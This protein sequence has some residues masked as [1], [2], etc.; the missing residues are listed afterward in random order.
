MNRLVYACENGNWLPMLLNPDN[1]LG[2]VFRFKYTQLFRLGNIDYFEEHYVDPAT[3]T[4]Y[5]RVLAINTFCPPVLRHDGSV[6]YLELAEIAPYPPHVL[7]NVSI[8][9]TG[10]NVIQFPILLDNWVQFSSF[11]FQPPP[12]P[13]PPPAQPNM[14]LLPA[15]QWQAAHQHLEFIRQEQDRTAYETRQTRDLLEQAQK[16]IAALRQSLQEQRA[17]TPVVLTE[18]LSAPMPRVETPMVLAET[19]SEPMPVDES[20]YE[21]V[22]VVEAKD[23]EPLIDA[24]HGE[25]LESHSR[26]VD[27]VEHPESTMTEVPK[28]AVKT[29][30]ELKAERIEHLK[31]YVQELLLLTA[32][33]TYSLEPV[34]T[35]LN[36]IT[37]MIINK[38]HLDIFIAEIRPMTVSV[39]ADLLSKKSV[40]VKIK[41]GLLHKLLEYPA[42]DILETSKKINYLSIATNASKD[43]TLIAAVKKLQLSL[44]TITE[45]T[46]PEPKAEP[47]V[48]NAELR[49]QLLAA[50]E[51]LDAKQIVELITEKPDLI[52]DARKHFVQRLRN[53]L[54]QQFADLKH[55]VVLLNLPFDQVLSTIHNSSLPPQARLAV[56]SCLASLTPEQYYVKDLELNFAKLYMELT[57]KLQFGDEEISIILESQKTAAEKW[58]T[59]KV[60]EIFILFNSS[61]TTKKIDPKLVALF[62]DKVDPQG[63]SMLMH[64]I[65]NGYGAEKLLAILERA[66][67]SI[68]KVDAQNHTIWHYF[69]KYYRSDWRTIVSI[70]RDKYEDAVKRLGLNLFLEVNRRDAANGNTYLHLF[71]QHKQEEHVFAAIQLLHDNS[72]KPKEYK[73]PFQATVLVQNNASES[74]SLLLDKKNKAWGNTQCLL[75]ANIFAV[76]GYLHDLPTDQFDTYF[77]ERKHFFY[78]DEAADPILKMIE[79]KDIIRMF[80]VLEAR[81]CLHL[82]ASVIGLA[83]L[84][85][86][87]ESS[88][89]HK[90]RII[91]Y[92]EMPFIESI[93]YKGKTVFGHIT[94]YIC[95]KSDIKLQ[96]MY[97]T[98]KLLEINGEFLHVSDTL[99]W[100]QASRFLNNPVQIPEH[101]AL[102]EALLAEGAKDATQAVEY[103][104]TAIH[105]EKF[106]L[107]AY[108]ITRSTERNR[109]MYSSLLAGMIIDHKL[110]F[111]IKQLQ[112]RIPAQNLDDFKVVLFHRA[113][114]NNDLESLKTMV[115]TQHIYPTLDNAILAFSVADM[116]NIDTIAYLLNVV[117]SRSAINPKHDADFSIKLFSS[118]M[119][120]DAT[121]GKIKFLIERGYNPAL[122]TTSGAHIITYMFNFTMKRFDKRSSAEF[123]HI[124]EALNMLFLHCDSAKQ[125]INLKNPANNSFPID[126]LVDLAAIYAVHKEDL[127]TLIALFEIFFEHGAKLSQISPK[128]KF[129]PFVY[130]MEMNSL[131]FIELLADNLPPG[132]IYSALTEVA[133]NGS[134]LIDIA[135]GKA[136]AGLIGKEVLDELKSLR[137]ES[138]PKSVFRQFLA[139]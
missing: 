94:D 109:F 129:N 69:A 17:K 71:L 63:Q 33:K 5:K 82:Q 124:H 49:K 88:E 90:I 115:E 16:E 57:E 81:V 125:L 42:K 97:A 3:S 104:K 120:T 39:C 121:G 114:N 10:T 2:F 66:G 95:E 22:A 11:Q 122:I 137:D 50:V 8:Y 127:S 79:T 51:N 119:L 67:D 101:I 136:N 29:R 43:S 47:K 7:A 133:N 102:I 68:V 98:S 44:T 130:A 31:K 85:A 74:S 111:V 1:T 55:I 40:P 64:A 123:I 24:K 110:F 59:D 108:A 12:V 25:D 72:S 30:A 77:P 15:V 28:V 96:G 53:Y 106:N 26:E 107:I 100:K 18:T 6:Y 73:N 116:A 61:A 86:S 91:Q 83:M 14:L 131:A 52:A 36:I 139:L 60:T 56:M 37:S 103:I 84:R 78:V 35:V 21:T 87:D 45:K 92:L 34:L 89:L 99:L 117:E 9:A 32:S 112:K 126:C 48:T 38:E 70:L 19:I 54:P 23:S 128:K 13:L 46:A 27:S 93:R 20:K 62:A 134:T 135:T 113:V 105:E 118:A 80:N 58:A 132:E 41:E 65:R 4:L 76:V 75:L 138:A